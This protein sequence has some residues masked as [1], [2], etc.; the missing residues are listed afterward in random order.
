MRLRVEDIIRCV[1]GICGLE[2]EWLNQ[3]ARAGPAK[4]TGLDARGMWVYLRLVGFFL[5]LL[6]KR[7]SLKRN[8]LS[9]ESEERRSGCIREQEQC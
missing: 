2:L 7:R 4:R 6:L 8:K 9:C 5:F 3:T 1:V